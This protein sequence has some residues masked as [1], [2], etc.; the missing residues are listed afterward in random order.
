VVPDNH[1]AVTAIGCTYPEAFGRGP[2]LAIARA[3]ERGEWT[4]ALHDLGDRDPALAIVKG[5]QPDIVL[6]F[7]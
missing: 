6:H 3:L 5:P 7:V 1:V 4:F 2:K